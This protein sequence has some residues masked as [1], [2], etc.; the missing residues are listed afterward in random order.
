MS[1]GVCG[2][3]CVPVSFDRDLAGEA[4]TLCAHFRFMTHDGSCAQLMASADMF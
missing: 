1:A 3:Q 2:P 4:N